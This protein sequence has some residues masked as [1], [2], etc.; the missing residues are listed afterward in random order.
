MRSIQRCQDYNEKSCK[1]SLGAI[2]IAPAERL[3]VKTQQA[4]ASL[5]FVNRHHLCCGSIVA[6]GDRLRGVGP[7]PR[8][9]RP[10]PF[11]PS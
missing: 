6:A 3:G 2:P 11:R 1:Y 8:Y 10:T 4:E 5:E 7:I 9:I